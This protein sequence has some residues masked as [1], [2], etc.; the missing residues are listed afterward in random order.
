MARP[1]RDAVPLHADED[2]TDDRK[3]ELD[4]LLDG[5]ERIVA[6]NRGT[7][8]VEAEGATELETGPNRCSA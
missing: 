4:G 2:L 3:S 6:V 8:S 5:A 7:E 1:G